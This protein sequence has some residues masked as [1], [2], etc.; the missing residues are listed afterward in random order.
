MYIYSK[1]IQT[2]DYSYRSSDFWNPIWKAF[3]AGVFFLLSPRER[4][5]PKSNVRIDPMSNVL[6][7]SSL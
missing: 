7:G 5:D 1:N 2:S 4:L 6:S 3:I